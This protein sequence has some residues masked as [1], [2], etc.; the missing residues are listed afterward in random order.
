MFGFEML[1][2]IL[3]SGS[4]SHLTTPQFLIHF[5]QP[6][7]SCLL[8]EI[9]S[10]SSRF[11]FLLI[12]FFLSRSCSETFTA[13]AAAKNLGKLIKSLVG[14]KTGNDF[15]LH[16]EKKSCNFCPSLV[17]NRQF[18]RSKAILIRPY[19]NEGRKF[20]AVNKSCKAGVG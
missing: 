4:C 13:A 6:Q 12:H 20:Y 14:G 7:N 10:S 2:N 16:L 1:K 9:V 8:G 11:C 5:S 18:F 3:A 15:V 19:R 17:L